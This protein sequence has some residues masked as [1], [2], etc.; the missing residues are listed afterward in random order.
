M[1][2][3]G[4]ILNT[5]GI[6]LFCGLIVLMAAHALPIFV[7]INCALAAWQSGAGI[8]GAPLVGIAAGAMT[9]TLGQAV[10]AKLRS[11]LLRTAL[12]AIFVAPAIVAGYHTVLAMASFGIPLS[13]WRDLFAGLGALAI[14]ATAWV[15]LTAFAKL[16][17]RA[18]AFPHRD[19]FGPSA[20]ARPG[21]S[22]PTASRR[23]GACRRD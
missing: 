5:V 2:A 3:L 15:R 16:P 19:D 11:G 22:S 14:G 18:I 21:A 9:H 17:D 12:A 13:P 7:A 23:T 20:P 6:G 10:F 1:L 8:L 4:V